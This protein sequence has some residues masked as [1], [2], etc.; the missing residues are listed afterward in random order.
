MISSENFVPPQMC[1]IWRFSGP[2]GQGLEKV[3]IFT[4]KGTSVRGSTSFETFCVKIGLGAWPA[5]RF[6][7]KVKIS[8]ISHIYPEA[9]AD[10]IVTKYG[11]GAD[12]SDIINYAK[13]R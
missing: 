8:Y 9:P 7:K 5:G 11:L 13:F 3:A 12:F 4:A 1:Q 2:G 10:P 6:G